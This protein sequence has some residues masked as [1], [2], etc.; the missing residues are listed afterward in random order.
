MLIYISFIY[1]VIV[2]DAIT[3]RTINHIE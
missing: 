1:D 2:K 3:F